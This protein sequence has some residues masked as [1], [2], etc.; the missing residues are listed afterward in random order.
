MA[1]NLS[2]VLRIQGM[3]CLYYT[4]L[5]YTINLSAELNVG[6]KSQDSEYLFWKLVETGDITSVVA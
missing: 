1:R 6:F 4:P 2:K 5:N 3:R